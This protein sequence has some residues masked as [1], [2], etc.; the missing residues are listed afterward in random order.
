M[1]EINSSLLFGGSI[2]RRRESCWILVE[3]MVVFPNSHFLRNVRLGSSI[4][5]RVASRLALWSCQSTPPIIMSTWLSITRGMP[6]Q[7]GSWS[8]RHRKDLACLAYRMPI[9]CNGRYP[10]AWRTSWFLGFFIEGE[11]VI[12]MAEIKFAKHFAIFE[13]PD[14]ILRNWFVS[15]P[16]VKA[17]TNVLRVLGFRLKGDWGTTCYGFVFIYFFNDFTRFEFFN[18]LL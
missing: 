18:A 6:C 8:S 14:K 13:F 2:S 9:S 4:R 15:Y 11:L 7:T 1:K 3:A 10:I 16:K 17:C 12:P 5:L